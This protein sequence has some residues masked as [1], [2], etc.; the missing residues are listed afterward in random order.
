M[1][2]R[3]IAK[4]FGYESMF[5]RRK[6]LELV[7]LF[8]AA[9]V[10]AGFAPKPPLESFKT[11]SSSLVTPVMVIGR[12]DRRDIPKNLKKLEG[13]IGLLIMH[14]R[15]G[16]SRSYMCTAFCV[17]PD[18]IATNAHC[19]V[20]DG[21]KQHRDLDRIS[22]NLRPD[23]LTR[24]FGSRSPLVIVDPDE[25]YLSFYTGYTR[26][27]GSL[28]TAKYDWAFAKL[29]NPIC[30]GHALPFASLSSKE[31]R[32]EGSKGK[33]FMLGYHGDTMLL[34]GPR[35]SPNC[36]PTVRSGG[37]SM[38]HYC[39][40]VKGSSGS[41]LLWQDGEQFKVV[42]INIGQYAW[43]RQR[44]YV[45]RFTGQRIGKPITVSSGQYNYATPPNGF[46]KG[47]RHF[48]EA[49]LLWHREDFLEYQELLKKA[50]FYKGKIDGLYGPA[51]RAATQKFEKS[52]DLVPIGLPTRGLIDVLRQKT[53]SKPRKRDAAFNASEGLE[54]G[55]AYQPN[56]EEIYPKG[57]NVVNY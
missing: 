2:S 16:S 36:R 23:T 55:A 48:R 21:R 49:K 57:H 40:M 9:L 34:L 5:R 12:D 25:P 15:E 13:S 37:G 43:R 31:L 26:S 18:V 14:G 1:A 7:A 27:K 46:M 20:R 8:G 17:A 35:Y 39:D 41:P 51:T 28:G 11:T 50:G 44:V 30:R 3:Q 19:L 47:V 53:N 45:N 33:I 4:I 29:R 54:P 38:R 56:I 6:R 10:L 42:G 32:R 52:L 24:T 22:F